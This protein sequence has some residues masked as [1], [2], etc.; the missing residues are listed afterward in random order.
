MTTGFK[1]FASV[2]RLSTRTP[3]SLG[4]PVQVGVV[5]HD[6]RVAG[7]RQP[8]ELHV[9]L[10]HVRDII[11][12]ELDVDE[13]LL[14]EEVEDLEATAAA[15]AAQRIAG[16]RDVLQ[17]GKHEMRHQHVVAKE[18]GLGNVHD[19]P[20]DDDAR[21]EQHACH[22]GLAWGDRASARRAEDER[23]HLVSPVQ[24]ERDAPV[25]ENERHDQGDDE[26][27]IPGQLGQKETDERR[28]QQPDQK[29]D[30]RRDQIW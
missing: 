19:A 1:A 13:R 29:P 14:L 25:R 2:L 5:G 26:A 27:Q 22:G 15:V 7:S 8:D 6:G 3:S 28:Q 21:I 24:P 12:D 18:T 10:G 23:H 9:D 16:V 20:V 11:V 4:D 17:L 30:G